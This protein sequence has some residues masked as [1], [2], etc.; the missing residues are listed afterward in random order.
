MATSYYPE[1][2]LSG[3]GTN[4]FEGR[5]SDTPRKVVDIPYTRGKVTYMDVY[6]R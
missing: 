3:D 6:F 1:C 2:G 5:C 4:G